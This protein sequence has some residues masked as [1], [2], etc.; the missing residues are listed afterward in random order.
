MSWHGL[1][2]SKSG[3]SLRFDVA[4]AGAS[5]S[6]QLQAGLLLATP[7]SIASNCFPTTL[8]RRA[9]L[10]THRRKANVV[11]TPT[12][13]EPTRALLSDTV[14]AGVRSESNHEAPCC[15]RALAALSGRYACAVGPRL[16]RPPA[17]P[18]PSSPRP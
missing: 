6:Q 2:I 12:P 1:L 3:N 17:P 11:S 16:W 5:A 7:Q 8:V 18:S 15:R 13:A 10:S 9:P 4:L 14:R